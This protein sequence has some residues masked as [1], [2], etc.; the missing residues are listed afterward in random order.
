MTNEEIN[1]IAFRKYPDKFYGNESEAMRVTA[2]RKAFI[3]GMK[4][5]RKQYI[6]T[7][8]W[9][10]VDEGKTFVLS[11][12]KPKRN[13]TINVNGY[14]IDVS[15]VE[16]CKNINMTWKDEPKKIEILIKK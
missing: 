12:K 2:L 15:P 4:A 5:M 16:V 6:K 8:A 14:W 7:N 9:I 13:K 3:E 10:A 1:K 11:G